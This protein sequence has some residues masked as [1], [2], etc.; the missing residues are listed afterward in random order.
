MA[1]IIER[2]TA[3]G[4]ATSRGGI[5]QGARP[6]KSPVS[7]PLEIRIADHTA[8]QASHTPLQPC[9]AADQKHTC[10]RTTGAAGDEYPNSLGR[11]DFGLCRC[12]EQTS[13]PDSSCRKKHESSDVA[14]H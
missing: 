12:R 11:R 13:H 1:Q 14:L 6:P 7:L 3:T 5:T 9:R 2:A 8:L 4:T 10:V